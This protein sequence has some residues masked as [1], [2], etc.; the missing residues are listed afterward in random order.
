MRRVEQRHVAARAAEAAD[1]VDVEDF[2]QP[3]DAQADRRG[4]EFF[5]DLGE[6]LA[7][8]VEGDGSA[9]AAD[10]GGGEGDRLGGRMKA[11]G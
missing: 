4:A 1:V 2:L 5:R 7:R 6:G 10:E 8:R 11:E 3:R 9:E